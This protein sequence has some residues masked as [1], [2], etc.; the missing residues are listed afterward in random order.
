[1]SL[2]C[3]DSPI[4]VLGIL[5]FI[6]SSDLL[7]VDILDMGNINTKGISLSRAGRSIQSGFLDWSESC[8]WNG[9]SKRSGLP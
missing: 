5:I 8:E 1:M 6:F 2:A 4:R 3:D 7:S 9:R